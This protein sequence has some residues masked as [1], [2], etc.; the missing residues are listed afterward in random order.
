MRIAN[1]MTT[2]RINNSPSYEVQASNQRW[3]ETLPGSASATCMSHA[4]YITPAVIC[5]PVPPG[6]VASQPTGVALPDGPPGDLEE[7]EDDLPF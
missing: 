6:V 1:V 4:P 3:L 7:V 2:V 5:E